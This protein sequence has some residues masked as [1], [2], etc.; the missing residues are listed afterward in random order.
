MKQNF[1]E[2]IR[3]IFGV[4]RIN[5]KIKLLQRKGYEVKILFL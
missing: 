3:M 1:I 5:K 2:I 4:R